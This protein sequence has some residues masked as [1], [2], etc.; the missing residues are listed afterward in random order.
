MAS[1][2]CG[3]SSKNGRDSNPRYYGLKKADGQSVL[4]GNILVKQLG[5]KFFPG[6]NVG[7]GRDWTLF[8]KSDGVVKF[9]TGFKR[10]K[11]INII[12]K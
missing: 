3:G 6:E 4:A 1:K 2:K 8:A 9:S 11:Y 12:L 5:T 7:L 10:R